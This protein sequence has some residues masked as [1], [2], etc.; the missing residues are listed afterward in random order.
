[1][2]E[3]KTAEKVAIFRKLF[4]GLPDA[5]GT[6]DPV[7]GRAWQV[8]APVTDKVL[9]DHLMGHRPYGV[10][11]LFKDRTRAITVDFDSGNQLTVMEFVTRAKHYGIPVYVE[12]SKS[13]GY[14]AWIFFEEEAVLAR[15]ARQVLRHLLEEIEEPAAEIFPK[16][17]AL[18]T[19]TQYGNFINAPLF[20]ALVSQGKTV[21]VDLMSFAP[22]PDQWGLLESAAILGE[23]ALDEII[24]LNDL[25]SEPI[26]RKLSHNSE[27]GSLRYGLPICARKMLRDGVS[28][29]QR[30]CC[31]RL[32]V[33]FRRLGL[34]ADMAVAALKTWAM[35]NRPENGK[36]VIRESEIVSQTMDG[37]SKSYAGYGCDSEAIKPFCEPSCPLKQ[38]RKSNGIISWGK[39]DHKEGGI[40]KSREK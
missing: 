25:S 35:K 23:S 32:A 1:M 20:G 14:H 39:P 28:Q 33:H 26:P 2:K 3:R 36:G 31:F 24:E 6:Y 27:N 17:D 21:F 29:K 22:Y 10:Y 37:Y 40:F 15:K 8:K 16:Q 13:K 11:L 7:S 12:R 4:T 19:N 18:D 38:Q 34:P 5:Y 30:V 9:L